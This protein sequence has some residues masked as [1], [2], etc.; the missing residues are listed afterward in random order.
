MFSVYKAY[1]ADAFKKIFVYAW[2][3]NVLL[4]SDLRYVDKSSLFS[5]LKVVP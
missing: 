1:H 3:D 2:N 5:F 4:R